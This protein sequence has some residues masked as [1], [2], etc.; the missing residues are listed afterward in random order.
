MGDKSENVA[1]SD[2]AVGEVIKQPDKIN[3][4]TPVVPA[5]SHSRAPKELKD[6]IAELLTALTLL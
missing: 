2:A 3:G 1:Q 4:N 6:E 5:G